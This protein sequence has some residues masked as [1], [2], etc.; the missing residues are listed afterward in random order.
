M[1]IPSAAK[2]FEYIADNFESFLNSE[3]L[4]IPKEASAKL[5]REPMGVVVLIVPWNYPFLIFVKS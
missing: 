2:T 3:N 4:N 1:D 5:K